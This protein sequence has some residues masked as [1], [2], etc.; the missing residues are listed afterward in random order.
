ME[1]KIHILKHAEVWDTASTTTDV[2]AMA[3]NTTTSITDQ[4]KDFLAH[5]ITAELKCLSSNMKPLPNDH[6]SGLKDG[7]SRSKFQH[8]EW[9]FVP[10][11]ALRD[12]IYPG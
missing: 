5:H 4:L 3:L 9:M 8:Q 12:K 10:N 6:G 7:E 1:D 2:P 11:S